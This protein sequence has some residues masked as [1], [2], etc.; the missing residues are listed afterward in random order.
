VA[1]SGG[2]WK[3]G[4][5]RLAG[6][7]AAPGRPCTAAPGEG[8]R[9]GSPLG[10][11]AACTV[12]PAMGMSWLW[13][14]E[15][16]RGR[17]QRFRGRAGGRLWDER[18]PWGPASSDLALERVRPSTTAGLLSQLESSGLLTAIADKWVPAA[19]RTP[20]ALHPPGGMLGGTR[21]CPL[22]GSVTSAPCRGCDRPAHL[23][24]FQ[25]L[26]CLQEHPRPDQHPGPAG[27]GPGCRR[28]VRG[29]RRQH[30]P[31]ERA[32]PPPPGGWQLRGS[33]ACTPWNAG[34][35]LSGHW[36]GW[37]LA[38]PL[39]P[40]VTLGLCRALTAPHRLSACAAGSPGGGRGSVWWCWPG[41]LL[42]RQPAEHPAE[43]GLDA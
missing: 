6:R 26:A 34:D 23:T 32:H 18:R 43:A 11:G 28:R 4:A 1:W 16:G 10:H 3:N 24:R 19:Q 27:A 41:R 35:V 39:H 8:G 5:C 25:C 14:A 30:R 29:A 40:R 15:R 7:R 21:C 38:P 42:G 17:R 22:C 13:R 31:G 36:P 33:R 37:L 2:K 20:A 12:W 9:G